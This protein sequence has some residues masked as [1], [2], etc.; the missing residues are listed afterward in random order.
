MDKG[1]VK[2]LFMVL[3]GIM[4]F[5]QSLYNSYKKNKRRNTTNQSPRRSTAYRQPTNS[6][7]YQ[8]NG[9]Q[10]PFFRSDTVVDYK[11]TDK[12][13]YEYSVPGMPSEKNSEIHEHPE[14]ETGRTDPPRMTAAAQHAAPAPAPT[15]RE[16]SGGTPR[17]RNSANPSHDELR[18]AVIWSEILKRKY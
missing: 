2:I 13:T 18:K 17:P 1:Q 5:G 7:G 14:P 15:E 12:V 3:I 6:A 4:I 16:S 8:P 11:T 10:T 9:M